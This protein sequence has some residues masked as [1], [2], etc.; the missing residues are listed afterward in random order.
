MS[1]YF[2]S[3]PSKA[4]QPFATETLMVNERRAMLRA[5]TALAVAAARGVDPVM[6][7]KSAWPDDR[8][9]TNVLRAV[10]SP[11]TTHDARETGA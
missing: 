7:L 11:T 10:S 9:A 5:I 2:P 1:R 3:P 6:V 8:N 4:A